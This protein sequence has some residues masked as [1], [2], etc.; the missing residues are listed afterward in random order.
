MTTALTGRSPRCLRYSAKRS[1]AGLDRQQRVEHDDALVAFDN[2]GV[3]QVHAADLVDA[4]D[5]LEQPVDRGE[6]ATAATD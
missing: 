5:D 1:R 2:R 6:P 3:R 4:L